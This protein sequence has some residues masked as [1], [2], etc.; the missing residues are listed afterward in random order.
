MTVRRTVVK[1]A[2]TARIAMAQADQA[3]G[4]LYGRM[5]FFAVIL[6]VFWSLWQATREAGLLVGDPTRLVWYLA[7]TEWVLLSAPVMH[8]ALQEAVRRG[9]VA[10]QLGRP[11]SYVGATFSGG[12]GVLMAR[13]PWLAAAGFVCA[14]AL[15]G[16]VPPVRTL[17][18][19]ALFGVL[20][21]GLLTALSL[22]IGLLAFWLGDV[23][24]V[25]WVW[26]KLLFVLGGLMLPLHLY[27]EPMQRL[28]LLTPFP[29][30]LSGPG[31]L[32]L[33]DPPMA[34]G[35]L[36]VR[37]AVWSVATGVTLRWL[38]RRVS[39]TLTLNGG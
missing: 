39:A 31:S 35:L 20:A 4:D 17:F 22:G 33:E 9:D 1:H 30:L 19:I 15:T 12:L 5:V 29:V 21:S 34:L 38:S 13:T 26:Q 8:L 28:A 24:P 32:V 18:A 37:L 10:Y 16:W 36:A 27:P 25:Y 7:I 2:A 23:S 14:F 3:R 6:G 11:I